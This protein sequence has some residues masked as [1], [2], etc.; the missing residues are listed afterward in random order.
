[1]CDVQSY[2]YMPLL[3][4]MGYMPKNK[5]AYGPEFSAHANAIT[6]KCDFKDQAIFRHEVKNLNGMTRE[7]SE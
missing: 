5:Y 3:E 4:E 2:I 7:S 6:E 1:M